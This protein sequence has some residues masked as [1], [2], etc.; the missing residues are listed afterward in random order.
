VRSVMAPAP[1]NSAESVAIA[2]VAVLRLAQRPAQLGKASGSFA[3]PTYMSIQRAAPALKCPQR[4]LAPANGHAASPLP[5][6]RP[7]KGP[8]AGS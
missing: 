6:G 5:P 4:R 3:L 1:P 7:L 8:V 2:S